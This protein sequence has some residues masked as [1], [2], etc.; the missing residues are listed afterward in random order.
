[1]CTWGALQDIH[2]KFRYLIYHQGI[3]KF[4][5][6]CEL[7]ILIKVLKYCHIGA[8]LTIVYIFFIQDPFADDKRSDDNLFGVER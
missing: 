5:V 2:I 7:L 6:N 3:P 4:Y 8:S 1:M